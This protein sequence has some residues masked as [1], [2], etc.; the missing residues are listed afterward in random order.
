MHFTA[1]QNFTGKLKSLTG[2]VSGDLSLEYSLK[3]IQAAD[4][5]YSVVP[6][7]QLTNN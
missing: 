2:K 5:Q 1:I 7:K 6:G 3:F 4:Y